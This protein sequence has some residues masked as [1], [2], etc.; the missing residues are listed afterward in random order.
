MYKMAGVVK[1]LEEN[2][3]V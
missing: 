2:S 1:G 3:G